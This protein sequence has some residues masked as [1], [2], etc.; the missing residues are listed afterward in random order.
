MFVNSKVEIFSK[1]NKS[2]VFFSVIAFCDSFPTVLAM[3]L[4]F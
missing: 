2:V 4:I 3:F 1:K